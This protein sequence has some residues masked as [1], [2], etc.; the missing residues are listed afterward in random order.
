MGGR[1]KHGRDTADICRGRGVNQE[2]L[3]ECRA[4]SAATVTF[5]Y[6]NAC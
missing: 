2:D 5:G 6:R 1:G 4:G 3:F